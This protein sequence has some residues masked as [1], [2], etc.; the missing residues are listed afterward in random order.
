MAEYTHGLRI[1]KHRLTLPLVWGAKS[2]LRMID[3]FARV[4]TR[5]DGEDLP[6]L[7][8]LQGG[9]GSEA[10]RPGD[11]NPS[12]LKTALERYRVV[13]IDQ[14]GTGLSTPVGDELLE[15]SVS[16]ATEYATH[17]RAD[18]IV[19]DCEAF[20]EHLGADQWSLLGQ[21]FG[22][23][24]TL[25]YLTKFPDSIAHAYF[26]GGLPAVGRTADEI[27]A[28]TYEKMAEKSAQYFR[29]FPEDAERM[30]QLHDLA[31]DGELRLP[32][33]D[34]VSPSMLK[35]LG[36]LLGM[37]NG[38][39]RLHWLLEHDPWSNAFRHDLESA[40]PFRLRNPLY[41]ILH[42]SSMSDG[43]RTAWAAARVRPEEFDE[44]PLLLTGEHLMPE[45]FDELPA[46]RPWSDVANALAD[47][48]WPKLYDENALRL[49]GARGAAAV[50]YG[51]VYVPFEHSMETAE[52][53]PDVRP[54]VTSEYEHDGL[55]SSNGKVLRHLFELAHGERLR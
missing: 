48:D 25:H 13:M 36:H 39:E 31:F 45:W 3:V 6:Y 18:S 32:N 23:F 29:W 15:M 42:E 46:W 19:R 28:L 4:I 51:D 40:L 35:S 26:T 5:R 14:R 24:C 20:R 41:L 50:Y 55:R 7:V 30:Q 44:D 53:L 21:S 47:V 11:G 38:A 52:L 10:P 1:E 12:W 33:G 37:S 8:Y 34:A 27:Y 9:P 17:L 16:E 43:V 54:W 22:G 2:D 49:S